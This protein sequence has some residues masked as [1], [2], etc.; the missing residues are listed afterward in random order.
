MDL[1]VNFG[2]FLVQTAPTPAASGTTIVVQS[3]GGSTFP[4]APFNCTDCIAGSGPLKSNSEIVRVT[5]VSADDPSAGLFTLTI[6]RAQ[7]GSTART[8][9]VGDQFFNSITGKY[10]TDIETE[11]GLRT[12]AAAALAAAQ[13]IK[14]DDF[15][16]PDDNTDLNAS[17][18]AHGLMAKADKVKLDGIEAGATADQTN[19][20]IETAYNAQVSVVSQAEAEA[21]SSTTV[22]RWTAQRVFQ[23][24]AA[25]ASGGGAVSSIFGRAGAVVAVAGD[26]LANLITFTPAG[27][28]AATN[29]QAAIEELDA[30]KQPL[31]SDLTAIAALT[32][33]N[34]DF[35]QRKSGAW[36]NRTV[37]QVKTDLS[38][39]GSN[40]GDQTNI[41]GNAATVTTNAN[42]TGHITSVGNAAVLGSFTVAQLNAAIS[43]ADVATGGGT[44]S[45]TNTGDQTSVSGNAG[46]ATA[47]A[48]PRSINGVNFDGTAAITVPGP[49]AADSGSTDTYVATLSPA[50]SSYVTGANYRFKANTANTGAAT[51][52]FNS[53]GAKPIVKATGGITTAL[54]DNDIRA[55]QWVELVYDGTNMQMQS[56]LGNAPAGGGDMLAANNLSDLASPK[57]GFDNISVHGADIASAG[58]IDLDAATGNVVDVT[59]T[60]TITAITLANGKERTV[61]FTGALTLT[62]GSSLV[63]P[64]SASI[65]TAAGDFAIFRGYA[66]S[67]VRCVVYSKLT[68][69][70]T[71]APAVGDVTGLATGIATFLATPSSTN[72][73]SAVTDES[74]TGPLAFGTVAAAATA[75]TIVARDSS[76]NS[77]SNN[78]VAGYTTT[79]TAAGTTTLTV[80][81]TRLQFLTGSTTQ[82]VTLPVTSTLALGFIFE[83][84]NNSTGVVTVNS[85]GGNAVRLMAPGS[86]ALFTCILITGTT[87]ASWDVFSGILPYPIAMSDVSTA[88]TAGTDKTVPMRMPWAGT[89]VAIRAACK[90]APT[91]SSIIINV[92]K[93][94]TTVFSTNLSIDVSTTTSV[95]SAAPVVIS[96]PDFAADDL[97]TFDFTQ[98]GSTIAGAGVVVAL[99]LKY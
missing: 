52:N 72:L 16:T 35:V 99:Y 4:T 79:A 21:G 37:A 34:D 3:V 2:Y 11:I 1:H 92:K 67:V 83:I 19:A 6:A 41:T 58:T 38:L 78:F 26:Y 63:L 77:T 31:D 50:I 80:A 60:T 47:L 71:I 13:A 61:R 29:V 91:G 85:S 12:T 8:I 86:R 33:S 87:A 25:L 51:I 70:P 45:G 5:N 44:A 43:D 36:T 96:V 56:T 94:G 27:S 15:A 97:F 75:S 28:V 64:G 20:E 53:V 30:E 17:S 54:A 66:S 46:T 65:T 10:F 57:T 7:E 22:R 59:G 95:G 81:S 93:N 88:I 68:G 89:L 48:T 39:S 49:F 74:G 18:G 69:K 98:V 82:T 76:A 9:V 90:T 42:L 73:A 23:A 40:T 55:G 14:L 62:H 32:P 84:E 24:I